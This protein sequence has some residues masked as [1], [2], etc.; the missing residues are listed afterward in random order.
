MKFYEN[1]FTNSG[2]DGSKNRIRGCFLTIQGTLLEE[3]NR[4]V[5]DAEIKQVVFEMGPLK[6]LGIDGIHALLYQQNWSTIGHSVCKF[7]KEICAR[8]WGGGT[9]GVAI[10]PVRRWGLGESP[11]YQ[12]GGGGEKVSA[13]AWKLGRRRVALGYQ[14][15]GFPSGAIWTVGS[16]QIQRQQAEAAGLD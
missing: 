11:D 6:A 16:C 10:G 5:S 7:V 15:L 4:Q 1:L 9:A 14:T 12:C 2:N 8:G 3:L 13:A